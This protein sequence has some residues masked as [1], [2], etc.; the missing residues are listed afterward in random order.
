[1]HE[2]V[3][4]TN[5]EV[6]RVISP[7]IIRGNVMCRKIIFNYMD[8]KSKIKMLRAYVNVLI[9]FDFQQWIFAIKI[10]IKS[11]NFKRRQCSKLMNRA[12]HI[13]LNCKECLHF[14]SGCV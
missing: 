4:I 1:M 14:C 7:T 12:Q 8:K 3:A 2:N 13:Y 5:Q 9:G 6:G 10:V 11:G